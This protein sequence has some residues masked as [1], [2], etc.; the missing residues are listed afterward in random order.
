MLVCPSATNIVFLASCDGLFRSTDH[1]DSWTH[2]SQD[3]VVDISTNV[4]GTFMLSTSH[5]EIYK[6]TDVGATWVKLTTDLPAGQNGLTSVTVSP[7]SSVI[8]YA[9]ISNVAGDA[10]LGL[11]KTTNG[12]AN[13][14]NVT[15]AP[16][17]DTYLNQG[18]YN[19]AIVVNPDDANM[20]WAGGQKLIRTSD[21]GSTW[22]IAGAP[23][24]HSDI[25]ALIYRPGD[26][27]LYVGCDGGVFSTNDEGTNWDTGINTLLPIAQFYNFSVK[28]TGGDVQLG[29]LQDNGFVGT[30]SGN[31]DD[32]HHY[33]NGDG[34][35]AAIDPLDAATLY[36]TINGGNHKWRW[37][38]TDSGASWTGSINAAMNAANDIGQGWGV[39]FIETP[40]NSSTL[41]TNA[42]N[43]A[44]FSTDKGTNWYRMNP[45]ALPKQVVRV[46]P[47]LDGSFVYVPTLDPAHPLYGFTPVG[48]G[49]SWSSAEI[50]SGLPATKVVKRVFPSFSSPSRA[51]ALLFGVADSYKIFKTTNKGGVWTNITGN[52][53]DLPVNGLVEDPSDD[54]RLWV[55]TDR[56]A[57]M[58]T[59]SGTNWIRWN[60]G[61]PEGVRITD[62]ELTQKDTTTYIVAAT[63]G[64]STFE[65]PVT[66]TDPGFLADNP[67]WNLG[68][69][70]YGNVVFDSTIIRNSGDGIL[71]ITD[72]TASYPGLVVRP[73]SGTVLPAE[74]LK[75]YIE[76]DPV[77]LPPGEFDASLEFFHNA[78]GS[79]SR[80]PV[81]A[82][83]GDDSRFRSFPAES[84]IVKKEVKRKISSTSW[85]FRFDN[86]VQQRDAASSLVVEFK[87]PVLGFSLHKP[88]RQA[89]NLDGKGKQW[90]FSDGTVT[91]GGSV[92]V[93]GA[94]RRT[95][96]QAVKSWWWEGT[97]IEWNDSVEQGTLGVLGE[98]NGSKLPL[99]QRG[100][101]EMPNAANLRKEVF[102]Q[103]PIGSSAPLVIGVADPDAKNKRVAYV[104]FS[105]DGD[106]YNSLITRGGLQHTGPPRPLDFFDNGKEM[107][108]KLRKL[109][110]DMQNNHLFAELVALR[111]DILASQL[112]KTPV[113]FGELRYI[114]PGNPLDGYLVR[115]I[116][117]LANLYM[118][119]SDSS[120]IGSAVILD[121]VVHRINGAFSG[122]R[123]TVSFAQK[124]AF[125]GVRPIAEVPFL[126][127]DPSLIPERIMPSASIADVPEEFELYQ[128]YPNPFNPAT[129]IRYSLAVRS[130]VTLNVY[131]VLG[132]QVASLADHELL[133]EGEHEAEFNAAALPSG[134]Y[135][136]RLVA[137][138]LPEEEDE[139]QGE[140]IGAARKMLLLR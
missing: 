97:H 43:F 16:P 119:Y 91:Y 82:Y 130:L 135:F 118:T 60:S 68:D 104:A 138:Q 65:R 28:H 112:A 17:L 40:R 121:S 69:I 57:F 114:D 109:T 1:G 84:L 76:F 6:S 103:V 83:V 54:T 49:S 36:G 62:L 131:N 134:V 107:I 22:N 77:R 105:R 116:D 37:R 3:H 15:P 46:N 136:Y 106:L 38:T 87:N 101:T 13:W 108:G 89:E 18:Y 73:T 56:G 90:K 59:N 122:P 53:P 124:L 47:N 58:S 126:Q 71:D 133:E 20:V 94:T 30:F 25:H 127:R 86:T 70:T 72:V 9:Q 88:F 102:A 10:V 120:A 11:F 137:Q 125:T 63:Y 115:Q 24:V 27:T 100:G 52:L 7:N 80:L 99:W 48:G 23:V 41:F 51:Y 95:Q 19:N 139:I 2:V 85:C 55:G 123:D 5:G 42:G 64:R 35:D 14:T 34:I 8:A 29:G 93:C 50:A 81:T 96:S 92:T 26:N 98:P 32:W 132:E 66:A 12:G 61:M 74:S 79:P 117:S 129:V 67:I 39:T 75:F 140:T 31:P 44:Y 128:N 33:L 45:S 113:G 110:P 111:L 78:P 21:G 4:S